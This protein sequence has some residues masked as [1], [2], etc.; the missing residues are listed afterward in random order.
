MLNPLQLADQLANQW[1]SD[2]DGPH[3]DSV[4]A[5]ADVFA[6]IVSDWFATAQSA[7]IPVVTAQARRS[8]LAGL[9]ISALMAQNPTAAGQ[10][11]GTASMLYMTGQLY[12]AGVAAPPAAGPAAGAMIAAV[13]SDLDMDRHARAAAIATA[14]H[15]MALTTIVAFPHPPF[16][17]PVT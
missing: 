4:A 11:L 13:F 16:A 3:A 17:A 12:G 7:G 14:L 15:I 1:L 9:A 5:S 2:A 10:Q 8:M 6:G